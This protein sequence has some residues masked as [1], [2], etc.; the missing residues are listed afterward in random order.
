MND[1]N[2]YI[3][4]NR[5]NYT[6]GE[7]DESEISKNPFEQF[8]TW[9]AIALENGISEPH[10]MNLATVDH[11]GKPSSRIV[12]LRSYDELG[13]TFY[14]NY[15][16]IKGENILHNNYVALNFFWQQLEMQIR[17]EGKAIKTDPAVSDAYF[18]SRPRESQLSAW[19]SEQSSILKSR[20]E[21]TERF[22]KLIAQFEGKEIPRPPHWGGYIV[23]A[24]KIEFWRG[25]AHRLHDRICYTLE[26]DNW[27]IERLSP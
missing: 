1:T 16:S 15:K 5:K 12:L 20:Q 8:S 13:F 24:G 9:F 22:E 27:K 10:A 14:T 21:L 7:L 18:S 11:S 6:K 25:R 4:T 23:K 19:T 17:I 2:E 26:N 3:Y